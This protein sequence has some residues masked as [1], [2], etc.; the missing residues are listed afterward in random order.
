M[1]KPYEEW[2][3]L[4]TQRDVAECCDLPASQVGEMFKRLD[5]PVINPE[6]KRFRRIQRAVLNE[7]LQKPR[8]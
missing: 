2:P 1:S 3:L 5:F 6:Y 7:Y 8:R 4:M